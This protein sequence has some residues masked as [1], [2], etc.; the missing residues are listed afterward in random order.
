MVTTLH[1][2]DITIVGQDR[3]F[4][5]ITRFGIER[6]DGVTAVSEFLRRMTIDEFQVKKPIEVIPNFVDLDLYPGAA[7]GPLRLRRARPEGAAP[8]LE[9]P[10]REARARRGA[11]LRAGQP[12]DGRGAPHGRRGPRALFGPG[13]GPAPGPPGPHPLPGRAAEHRGDHGHGRRGPPSL[14]ARELRAL[15]PRGHGLRGARGRLRRG[16]PA[17]GGE[18]HRER[19]PPARGR[20]GGDGRPHPRDPEGRR[21]AA[22]DGQGGPAARGVAV[23]RRARGL[24]ATRRC[25]SGCSA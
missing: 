16:R 5:E 24:A 7:P 1:G 11:H 18:A 10:A 3:S 2:T 21:A 25:T 22:R 15:R 4:F 9:L 6:S 17:R 19:L 23:R 13:P 8:R 20:R 14:R 12:G